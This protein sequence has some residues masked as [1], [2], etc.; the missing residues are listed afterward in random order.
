MTMYRLTATSSIVRTEDGASIPADPANR[1]YAAFLAWKQAGGM[2]EAYQPPPAPV[3]QVVTRF[4]ALAALHEAGHLTAA[5]ALFADPQTPD[6]SRLAWENATEFWRTS[7]TVVEVA[8]AL[9]L[10]GA[11]LDDLFTNAAQIEA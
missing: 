5:Q 2:P 1:D 4:Q 10:D 9:G 8:A 3:P 11:A 7:P 6:L